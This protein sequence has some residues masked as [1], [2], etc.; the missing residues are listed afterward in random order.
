MKHIIFP[1]LFLG[2]LFSSSAGL[3]VIVKNIQVG[4]GS[5]V[6]D[7][8]NSK[9]TF[10]KKAFASKTVKP[11][12]TTVELSF[13][14]PEGTYAVAGYQDLNDNGILDKGLF[15]IPKEPYGLSNNFRPKWSTPKYDDCKIK[16]TQQTILTI[17]LK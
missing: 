11:C 16:V 9:E 14:I 15:N 4:K 5:I 7:I 3:N 10:F 8:Y 12:S 6:V 1:I 17:I 2:A 13:D